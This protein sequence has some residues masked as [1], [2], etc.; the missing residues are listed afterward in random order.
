MKRVLLKLSGEALAGEQKRGFDEATVTEVAKQIKTIV[1]E[2]LQ[3]GIVIGGGNFWR[4]RTSGA[5]DRSKA[6]QIGMLATI[7]N[8][9]YVSDICRYVGLKTEVFTPFVCGAFTTLYSKDAVEESFAE[10]KV[11][12]FAGG[13]GHPYF[14]T[15]TATVLRA[16]EIGADAILLAKAVDG[17]YDSDPKV[18]PDAKKYDEISIDEVVAKKLAAMDLTASIM[19][20]EQKMP[21]L[22][23]GLDEKD[24]I[25]NT[26]H[27]KFS[28]TKVTV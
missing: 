1:D 13:T 18:N 20:M 17:I 5:M 19:C 10:G 25:V 23:F 14:S 8:C 12:F 27:G 28:G 15:D 6:D 4:G 26:V 7:M 11:V 22:V 3:V 21:M 16:V 2:G 9:I 24:S